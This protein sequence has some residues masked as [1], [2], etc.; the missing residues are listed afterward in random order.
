M[1]PNDQS[2]IRQM[3]RAGRQSA[4]Q[5]LLPEFHRV[6][7]EEMIRAMGEKY[8]CHPANYVKRLAAPLPILSEPKPSKVLRAKI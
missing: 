5:D 3:I 1:T 6:R 7:A 4:I 2:L 8:I